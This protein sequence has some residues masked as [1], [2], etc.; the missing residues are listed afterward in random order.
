MIDKR[1][2]G[3]RVRKEICVEYRRACSIECVWVEKN[4]TIGQ[5]SSDICAREIYLLK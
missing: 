1:E 5:V 3:I 2:A 4:V